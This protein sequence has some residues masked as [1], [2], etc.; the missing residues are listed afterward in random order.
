LLGNNRKY[1]QTV[2]EDRQTIKQTDDKENHVYIVV[3]VVEDTKK[4]GIISG[5]GRQTAMHRVRV[6]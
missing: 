2:G 3:V 5:E 6:R 4:I 1:R